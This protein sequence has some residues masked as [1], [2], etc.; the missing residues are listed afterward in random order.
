MG[1]S[2]VI[3]NRFFLEVTRVVR[4]GGD[5]EDYLPFA[6]MISH[7]QEIFPNGCLMYAKAIRWFKAKFSIC[8]AFYNFIHPY[9]TPSRTDDRR[10]LPKTPAMAAG[11]TNHQWTVREL[12]ACKA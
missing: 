4:S 12:L 2:I 1:K 11:V 6:Q 10:F 3:V 8:V 7:W 9:E 5:F